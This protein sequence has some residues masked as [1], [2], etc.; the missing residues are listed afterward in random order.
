MYVC[1]LPAIS[2]A[3]SIARAPKVPLPTSPRRR[4]LQFEQAQ[5][6]EHKS[7]ERE[8]NDALQTTADT[9]QNTDDPRHIELFGNQFGGVEAAL[10]E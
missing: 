9:A 7:H 5:D 3:A 2:A 6:D 8:G 10:L 1:S 4:P